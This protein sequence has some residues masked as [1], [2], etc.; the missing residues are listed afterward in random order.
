M[1]ILLF[2]VTPIREKEFTD[3]DQIQALKGII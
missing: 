3:Q 1:L 2:R